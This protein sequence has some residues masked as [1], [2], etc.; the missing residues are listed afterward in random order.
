MAF[1][2]LLARIKSFLSLATRKLTEEGILEANLSGTTE[3]MLES[4]KYLWLFSARTIF[5]FQDTYPFFFH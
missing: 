4:A 5:R 2:D 3:D 1:G